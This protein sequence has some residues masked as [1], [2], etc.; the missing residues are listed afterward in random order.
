[1]MSRSSA[2]VLSALV[3]FVGCN[4]EE[5][6]KQSLVTPMPKEEVERAEKACK[7]YVERVCAC[8]KTDPKM[9]EECALSKGRPSALQVNL[10]L[11]GSSGLED[12]E[13]KAVKVEARKIAAACFEA[14]ARLESQICP[15]LVP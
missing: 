5:V 9:Q 10:E 12:V 4:K 8:A 11:L 1:M 3:Q 13:L 7:T 14:D 6:P 2:L 15:R